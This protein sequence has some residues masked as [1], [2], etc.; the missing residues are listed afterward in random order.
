MPQKVNQFLKAKEN[1]VPQRKR[2]GSL[3][4]EDVIDA[5]RKESA[6]SGEIWNKHHKKGISSLERQ[7]EMITSRKGTSR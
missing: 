6:L 3:E 5:S 1:S 7:D 2:I 4:G